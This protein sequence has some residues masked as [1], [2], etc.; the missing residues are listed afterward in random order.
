MIEPDGGFEGSLQLL[1]IEWILAGQEWK[2]GASGEGE[3]MV[4]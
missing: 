1:R 4:V 3:E 2:S